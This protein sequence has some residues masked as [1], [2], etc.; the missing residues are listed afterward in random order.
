MVLRGMDARALLAASGGEFDL[1]RRARRHGPRQRCA[2]YYELVEIIDPATGEARKR[3]PP[4]RHMDALPPRLRGGARRRRPPQAD[5][6]AR[7]AC[8]AHSTDQAS[9]TSRPVGVHDTQVNVITDEHR[10]ADDHD[11]TGEIIRR[12]IIRTDEECRRSIRVRA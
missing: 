4:A 5:Q 9:P 7:Q 11:R 6:V 12:D 3:P 2:P 8:R 1:L 10:V